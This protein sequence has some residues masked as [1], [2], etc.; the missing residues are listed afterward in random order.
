[1]NS[2]RN[3]ASVQQHTVAFTAG[4]EV[5]DGIFRQLSQRLAVVERDILLHCLERQRSIHS[6][7][8]EIDVP[9]LLRQAGC[10]RALAGAGRAVDGDD[11][12][13]SRAHSLLVSWLEASG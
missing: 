2:L 9:Q 11:Q 10:D 4:F 8:L 7:A 12:L 1:A 6:A 3:I 5:D 13:A